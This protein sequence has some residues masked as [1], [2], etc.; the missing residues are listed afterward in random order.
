MVVEKI[1]EI[2]RVAFREKSRKAVLYWY[3]GGMLVVGVCLAVPHESYEMMMNRVRV[4]ALV[5]F[6]GMGARKVAHWFGGASEDGA[7]DKVKPKKNL[8]DCILI[9]LLVLAIVVI[10]AYLLFVL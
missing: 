8:G 1:R 5:F 6:V 10:V 4:S 3:L 7:Q 9:G 2:G